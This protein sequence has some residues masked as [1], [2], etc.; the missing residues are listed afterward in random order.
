MS[1]SR[2]IQIFQQFYPMTL[3]ASLVLSF[4]KQQR[5]ST[6]PS[7]EVQNSPT[8]VAFCSVPL[9]RW[10]SQYNKVV[11]RNCP[12]HI[13]KIRKCLLS[14][15]NQ[16]TLFAVVVQQATKL[17]QHQQVQ[18]SR[19]HDPQFNLQDTLTCRS[20]FWQLAYKNT[21]MI[22]MSTA[23]KCQYLVVIFSYDRHHHTRLQYV[24]CLGF[25]PYMVALSQVSLV[26]LF[27]HLS[28]I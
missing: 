25:V 2:P 6:R 16:N 17:S 7:T 22:N 23:L 21:F 26:Y 13:S 11:L 8:A 4:R 19:L 3:A 28:L 27:G 5:P 9:Q 12:N 14:G 24:M 10:H 18:Y 1:T 15:N 20:V